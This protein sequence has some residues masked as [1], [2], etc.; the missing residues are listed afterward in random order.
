MRSQII[1]WRVVVQAT[2]LL[3]LFSVTVGK[4]DTNGSSLKF[5]ITPRES[6]KV[7][8]QK[9]TPLAQYLSKELGVNVELVVGKEF[10]ATIDGLGKNEF[11]VALLTPS[12]YPKCERQYPDAG[13][14]PL[15]RFQTG[16]AGIYTTCIFVPAD[17]TIS[18]LS[19]LKGKKFAFG[20]A[21]S[22]ASHLMPKMMLLDAGVT[23][24]ELAE[25]K[26]LGSHTNVAAAVAVKTYDAGGCMD[27]VADRVEKEGKIK[28]IA[29]SREMPDA[30]ICANNKLNPALADRIVQALLKLKLADAESH[31]ILTSINDKYTG[32]EPAE[33]KDYD[34]IREM[35]LKLESNSK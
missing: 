30:P 10:Q 5:G 31:T 19:E 34:S 6:P 28:I 7:M 18:S 26:F 32:C 12:A 11:S 17:S 35:M 21:T 22:A 20:D 29:R 16:G 24:E 3:G 2:L 4:A 33:S 23:A 13:V 1:I 8:Y 27:S 25:S 9:F 14:R 15:V